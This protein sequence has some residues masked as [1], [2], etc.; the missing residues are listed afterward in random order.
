MGVPRFEAAPLHPCC[1]SRSPPG[2]CPGDERDAAARAC[3]SALPA[4][5]PPAH[6]LAV[7]TEERVPPLRPEAETMLRGA[8]VRERRRPEG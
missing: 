3:V 2:C 7:A 4:G 5:D 6:L 8:E 1:V